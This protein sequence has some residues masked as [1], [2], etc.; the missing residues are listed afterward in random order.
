MSV[1]IVNTVPG[2]I[3]D[4]IK[5][6][7]PLHFGL[8]ST[9]SSIELGLLRVTAGLSSLQL[10]AV[11]PESDSHI[12][13]LGGAVTLETTEH[14]RPIVSATTNSIVS[15]QLHISKTDN[16][17]NNRCIY[18]VKVPINGPA[19]V[20]GY[21]R[22]RTASWTLFSPDWLNLSNTAGVYLGLEHG[23]F[24][25]AIY[26]FLRNV[27]ASDGSLVVGGVLP[28]YGGAR[29]SQSEITSFDW[30]ALP[31]DSEIEVYLFFNVFGYPPPFSPEFVP[32]V[33]V[34]TRQIGVD[35][36]PV[37]QAIIPVGALGQFASSGF[38]N[39][40]P[41]PTDF[42]TFYFGLAGR[43][44]DLL[45]ID[46]FA[47][48]PD[49]RVSVNEG[50]AMP[51]SRIFALP[52]AP[53]VYRAPDG[54]RP[55][56]LVPGR[57]IPT[58]DSG[59][60][61]PVDALQYRSGQSKT[62]SHLFL[63]KSSPGRS[64]WFKD[65]PRLEANSPVSSVDG[66]MI[67]AFMDG[68]ATLLD[69]DAVGA[70]IAIDDGLKFYQV[71]MVDNTDHK[72]FGLVK[73]VASIADIAAGY[74]TPA[75]DQDYRTM[76]LVRLVVDRH[77][78]KVAVDI[79]ESRVIEQLTSDTFPSSEAVGGRV[80]FGHIYDGN[81]KVRQ[82]VTFLNYLPRYLA[83]ETSD[84]VLPPASVLAFI[85]T[86]SGAG[87]SVVSVEDGLQITKSAFGTSGS[88]RFFEKLHD[89]ESFGGLLV[90]FKMRI[91]DFTD[92]HGSPFTPFTDTGTGVNI[93]FGDKRLQLAFVDAGIHGKKIGI[94]PGS[95]S[96]DDLINQTTLGVAFS[97]SVDWTTEELYR[98]VYRGF[99][100]IEVWST[101]VVNDPIITIPW[102]ND[103]DG[104][105]LPTD[106]TTPR[107]AFGHFD[108]DASSTSFWR[109]LRWG[110]SNG[111]EVAVQQDVGALPSYLFGGHAFVTVNVI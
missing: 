6:G 84:N 110:S 3:A 54:L 58:R 99:D 67:E 23:V 79:D 7:D 106:A 44:G 10:G 100:K 8:K 75:V 31:N 68:S 50:D 72:T 81:T 105:D 39:F 92:V 104:F 80:M 70:G 2:D 76:K 102:R 61:A 9:G 62:P 12:T 38:D 87:S 26:S 18:E 64:A 11:V 34:W 22:F 14:R 59:E 51:G 101:S 60:Y 57:W 66:C 47:L 15:E 42:A 96:I 49:Y 45:K 107:I 21:I 4:P 52:D 71:L 94:V 32:V 65:E 73:S 55:A 20:L 83:Y 24:N 37:V 48:F 77:R 91:K 16:S 63:T 103:T 86:S 41:A 98:I 1:R 82:D 85:S 19:S 97:A 40:R 74:Y 90:D 33:E 46:D 35:P 28:T 88:K 27:P 78:G 89:F 25:T 95:G 36:V 69:G 56:E 53:V 108:E 43:S 93:F 13:K 5:P 109:Y 17:D 29:P 111:Y 30:A